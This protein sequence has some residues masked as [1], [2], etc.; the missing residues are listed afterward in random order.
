MCRGQ[1]SKSV[2]EEMRCVHMI[3]KKTQYTHFSTSSLWIYLHLF[4]DLSSLNP[5]PLSSVT[6]PDP[7]IISC[8]T[9][10]IR[11]MQAGK[12]LEREW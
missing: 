3:L 11:L 4:L 12:M 8:C 5:S 2:V 1:C 6:L 7:V 9:G 10:M